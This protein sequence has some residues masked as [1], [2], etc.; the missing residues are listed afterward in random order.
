MSLIEIKEGCQ[1]LEENNS[2]Q[3]GHG[4]FWKSRALGEGQ[5]EALSFQTFSH[6]HHCLEVKRQSLV[7]HVHVAYF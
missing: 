4:N 6:S 3:G 7:I 5:K 2:F 1:V